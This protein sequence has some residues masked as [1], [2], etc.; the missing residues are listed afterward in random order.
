MG[1][2]DA[3]GAGWFGSSVVAE[4]PTLSLSTHPIANRV[5]VRFNVAGE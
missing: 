5:G 3:P 2:V 1:R 4:E